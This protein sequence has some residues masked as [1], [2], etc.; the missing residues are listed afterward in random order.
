MSYTDAKHHAEAINE[1]TAKHRGHEPEAHKETP[2]IEYPTCANCSAKVRKYGMTYRCPV[3][4]V[5]RLVD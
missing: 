1:L 3:C 5:S 2:H 4:T